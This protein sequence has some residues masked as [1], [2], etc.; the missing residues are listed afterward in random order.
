[1]NFTVYK[2]YP[3]HLLYL[4]LSGA[5]YWDTCIT[6]ERSYFAKLNYLYYNPVKH[7]YVQDP[8]EYSFGSYYYR[9]KKEKLYLQGL[10]KKHPCDGL[11]LED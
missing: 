8:A 2:V 9:V 1:M 7:G 11:D 5:K 6:Y 4:L 10:I 3:H